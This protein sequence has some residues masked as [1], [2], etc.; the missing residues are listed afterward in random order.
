MAVYGID[1]G[2]TDS[3]I[4]YVDDAGRP[5]VLKSVVGEDT[6]PSVVYFESP[7]TVVVGRPAK[8]YAALVPDLVVE[9][10]KRQMG[11]DIHYSFQGQEHT[12]E[13]ISAFILRELA[14]AAEEQ[15]G[16]VVRDVVI[17]VPAYFGLLQREATRKAG[18]IAGLNVLDVL[19][20]PV[21]AA[22]AYQALG[23]SSGVQH[24][25]LY[26]LGGGT[27]DTTVIRIEDGDIHVVCTDGDY[28][29]GGVD[30][31]SVIAD[32]LLHG[33]T[34]QY[35]QLDPGGDEQFMQDLATS[36][37]QLKKALSATRARK[38]N[39]RFDG[40]VAQLEL[41]RA[42]LEGLTSEL[43]ER[44][45]EITARTIAA[46]REKGVE[47]FDDVLLV[48]GMTIL[49]IIAR[50]LKERFGLD[51][52]QQDPHLAVAKG[53]ALFALIKTMKVCMPGG[54][55]SSPAPDAAQE[56]A[57]QLGISVEQ[58]KNIAAKRVTTVVARAFGLK[59]IDSTDPVSGADPERAR[60]YISHL[61]AA[62]TPLPADTGPQIFCTVV[63][64]QREIKLEVWEQAGSIASE[65]L[66]H[67]SQ[68]GQAVLRNLPPRPA[69]TP[70]EVVFHMT[71]TGLL[72]VHGR[73]ADSGQ[74][75]RFE[76]QVGGLDETEIQHAASA[77]AHYE[78]PQ[79]SR[80]ELMLVR[81][82]AE[83][84]ARHLDISE[85]RA[86]ELADAMVKVLTEPDASRRPETTGTAGPARPGA[87]V[88]ASMPGLPPA[89]R[90]LVGR[91]PD[92]VR[93]GQTFSLLVSVIRSI[94]TP[95]EGGAPLRPFEVPAGGRLLTLIIDAPGFRVLDDHRQ[96]VRVPP[97][98]DSEPVKFD[99]VGDDPGP[100]RI[101]ITA[102][103][104]G[105]YLG[106]LAVEISVERDGPARPDRTAISEAREE[107]TDGEVTLLVRYDPHQTAYRF[108]FI[109]VDYPDEVASQLVYDPGPAVERLIR[110][111]NTM[112]EGTADYSA[113]ATR[114]YLVNEGVTLWQELIPEQLRS[115][116]WERQRRITQLTI[117]T[118]RDVVPWELLY[119][120]DRR[121]DA[122][123]LVEQ[124]PVTRAIYGHA[125][126]R[127]LRLQPARFV[128]PPG[129]PAEAKAEAEALARLLSTKL[130]TVSELMPLLRLITQG[131]FGLLH[132]ACHNR[133]DPDDGSSIRL[134]SPFSP[135][136][137]ATAASDQTLARAAPVIFINA[138]RS[139][140]Q[141]PSYNKL[142]GWAEKFLRAGAGA[143]IG[144]LWD[145]SDGMAREFAQEL[146]RRLVAGE[147]LGT[148]IMAARR[149]VA[150]E[151]GDPTWLAYTV[152][153]DPQARIDPAA[154]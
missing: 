96:A 53:A 29:L 117:L 145:V 83:R 137:L 5:V 143:F 92:T 26:D 153:G 89:G 127:R 74:E 126:Q 73:E 136:F 69:G 24:I 134:D 85:S 16:E 60:E 20:E 13:S 123:F 128:V 19:A 122:G 65:E 47:R 59:V 118:N 110:R 39:V 130:T 50:T 97:G 35:P 98:G 80:D 93:P 108:E 8:D 125:R 32:F 140:G 102:W 111:L 22:L 152:Y 27:F 12:P 106:E 70:F 18:Q 17:T 119:P 78:R 36:A 49:P 28:H 44:T 67:N 150:A 55:D 129:S 68:I 34:D 100:R 23:S 154:K 94:G 56:V 51:A 10:I 63:D 33:F 45:M 148:A 99:L 48:G 133:F 138:C 30:W 25:L 46:A 87:G 71:E 15:T 7:E 1:L 113:A 2:T 58:V 40:R 149:A 90:Y 64:N 82:V 77:V 121:H 88:E 76:I 103:D 11:Q 79:L 109:D 86:G 131:R 66:E 57:D 54:G 141:I 42:R 116:F 38:Y 114:A 61:L 120:K 4:A 139:L 142:D 112:A 115:Q 105:S 43:L 104:G 95:P 124:F 151:P 14:R 91:F 132:F 52:R 84:E 31:D 62:N 101:S 72:S 81:R 9:L 75:V 37:E 107:Q 146:Y 3:R 144:S 147:R 41:T 21:A 135:T 6:T